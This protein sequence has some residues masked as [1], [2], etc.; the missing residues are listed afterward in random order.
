MTRLATA[1]IF[2][3]A[4]SGCM[5]DD[6]RTAPPPVS[7]FNN[8]ESFCTIGG[9]YQMQ[10]D[11]ISDTCDPEDELVFDLDT[12]WV[13][14]KNDPGNGIHIV[15]ITTGGGFQWLDVSVMSDGKFSAELVYSFDIYRDRI[16][17]EFAIEETASGGDAIALYA[18]ISSDIMNGTTHEPGCSAVYELMGF[19]MFQ[20][21]EPPIGFDY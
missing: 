1:I 15:H 17:G 20:A 11:E 5:L 4:L 16:E 8:T 12:L 14:V 2:A 21:A 18:T 7:I 19:Q 9:I 3:L 6:D 10:Y 13:M